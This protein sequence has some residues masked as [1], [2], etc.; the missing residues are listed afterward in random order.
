M[1]NL[2]EIVLVFVSVLSLWSLPTASTLLLI[3]PTEP[4]SSDGTIPTTSWAESR[5]YVTGR[6]IPQP[7]QHPAC[8]PRSGRHD[9]DQNQ[10]GRA[11]YILSQVLSH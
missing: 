1:K 3:L 4:H 5:L 7:V 11:I 10:R 2:I 8:L 6:C 9:E